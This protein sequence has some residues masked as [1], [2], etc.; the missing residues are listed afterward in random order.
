MKLSLAYIAGYLDADGSIS[1]SIVK[2]AHYRM[3]RAALAFSV[4]ICGQN[5]DVLVKIMNTLECGDI[6]AYRGGYNRSSGAYRYDITVEHME[7]VLTSLIPYL[8]LK[9]TQAEL[10]L[11]LLATR[12]RGSH[13]ITDDVLNLRQRIVTTIS[14]LNRRDGKVY[15]SKWVNSVEPS[16]SFVV[17]YEAIPSQAAEGAGNIV[18]FSSA[19]GVTT[20]R[21]SPNNNPDHETPPRKGRDSLASNVS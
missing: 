4:N 8:Q 1:A 16:S 20:S 14:E 11:A 6:R 3:K 10:V 5:L 9:K 21:V 18:P 13:K 2:G 12:S 15:R 7:R 17:K 19:E